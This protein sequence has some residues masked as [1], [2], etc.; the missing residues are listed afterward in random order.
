MIAFK[1]FLFLISAFLPGYLLIRLFLRE[2]VLGWLKALSLSFGIGSLFVTIQLFIFLFICKLSVGNWIFA[3]FIIENSLL[4]FLYYKKYGFK[5]EKISKI[6]SL[7]LKEILLVILIFLQLI[8]SLSNCLAR[9]IIAYDSLAVWTL[10]AKILFYD[11]VVN[12]NPESFYYLGGYWHNNYPWH[13]SLLQYWSAF[14]LKD[15]NELAINLIFFIFFASVLLLI[16]SFLRDYINRFYALLFTFLLSSMPLFFYHSSNPYSDLPLSYYE[17]IGFIFLFK[18]IERL[19]QNK[20]NSLSEVDKEKKMLFW[21][22]LFFGVAFLV[23]LDAI[24]FAIAAGA[25]ILGVLLQKRL[26]KYSVGWK[27]LGIFVLGLILPNIFWGFFLI[28]YGLGL[29]NIAPAFGWHPEIFG[30]FLDSLFVANNWNIW[31]IVF[32]TFLLIYIK[33]IWRQKELLWGYLFVIIVSFGFTILYLF[34]G[35]YEFV[36][37]HTA[38]SRNIMLFVPISVFLTARLLKFDPKKNNE[39][40]EI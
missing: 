26:M 21:I 23:K 40:N 10:R 18:W 12:S 36:I 17:L 34:T 25:V 33:V 6:K 3:L 13:S 11:N 24:I 31:W 14:V 35:L 30:P 19:R 22:G 4:L 15:F 2:A 20:D 29:S 5:F 9:P 38:V 39:N 16:Y 1:F 8:F 37:N 32:F 27:Q 7:K 28:K